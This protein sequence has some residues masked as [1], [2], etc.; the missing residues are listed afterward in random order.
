MGHT[1]KLKIRVGDECKKVKICVPTGPTGP[2]GPSGSNTTA[3]GGL[4]YNGNSNTAGPDS[5]ILFN[6]ASVARNVTYSGIT[7]VFTGI[8]VGITGVYQVNYRVAAVVDTNG[9][10]GVRHLAA[11]LV[12]NSV[13]LTGTKGV[14]DYIQQETTP[15]S[16]SITEV[17]GS[18]L[19][20][21]TT[22]GTNIQLFNR[23]TDASDNPVQISTNNSGGDGRT[24]ASLSVN[25]LDI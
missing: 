25:R 21:V 20:D 13:E 1:K 4:I 6:N 3:F 12:V 14:I 24:W 15:G 16:S 22:V 23:S 19:V 10:T 11:D 7:G 8:T 2:T 18:Y 17:T 5:T 9:S